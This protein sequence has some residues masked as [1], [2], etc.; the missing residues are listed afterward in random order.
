MHFNQTEKKTKQKKKR[1]RNQHFF[2]GASPG[3]LPSSAQPLG[4]VQPQQR[5]RPDAA[6]GGDGHQLVAHQPGHAAAPR[7]EKLS[8]GRPGRRR[9]EGKKKR[10]GGGVQTERRDKNEERPEGE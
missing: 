10:G 5:L 9:L 3:H 2:L 6:A 7:Q 8:D 4:G 1:K